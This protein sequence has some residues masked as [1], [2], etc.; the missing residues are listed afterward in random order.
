MYDLDCSSLHL[1]TL[2]EAQNCQISS[3]LQKIQFKGKTTRQ[4]NKNEKKNKK[5]Q[6]KKSSNP[7]Q[8]EPK[9][10]YNCSTYSKNQILRRILPSKIHNISQIC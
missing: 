6:I 3:P 4:T 9:K 10:Q 8:H 2:P 7:F 1:K 5:V